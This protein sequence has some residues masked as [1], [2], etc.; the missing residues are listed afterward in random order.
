[1]DAYAEG[2]N[3]YIGDREP[4]ELSLE[5][6]I[7]TGILNR[8]YVIEPWT[9][10][11]SLTWGKA[12]AWDLRGNMGSEIERAILLK[13]F[14][15]E[16]VA[17][18]FPVYPDDHPI[19]VPEIGGSTAFNGEV[20]ELKISPVL[21]TLDLQ[22][23]AD[24]FTILDNLLGP[25]GSGIGSNSWAVSGEHTS[26][27][28]PL[29]AN[30]PHLGIQMPSI[31]FQINLHC[32]Q[33][34]EECPF[35]VGGFSFAGVPGVVIGHNDRI[36]W[37]VTNAGPDVMDLYIEK[38]NPDNPNQYEVNGEWVDFDIREEIINVAGDEPYTLTV[39]STRHGPVLTDTYGPLKDQVDLETNP[40]AQPFR[41]KAGVT[42]PENYVISLAWTALVPSSP[43]EAI[44]GFNTAQNWEE[45]REAAR[46]FHVPAQNLIYADV[47]GNIAYQMPGD[48]P[49]RKNG[50]GRLPVPGWTDE[51]E[52]TGYIPFEELPYTV[53]PPSGYIVT[54]NNQVNPWN[55][56]YL[57]STEWAYGF[58]SARI[59][60]MIEQAPG[61]AD[62]AFFQSI[63]GDAKSLNAEVLVPILL[64]ADLGS[65]LAD[66][67]D[68]FFASWDYQEGPDSQ[69]AALFEWFWWNLVMDTFKDDLPENYWPG[70]GS[71]W[72]EVMRNLVDQPN[73][74]WWDDQDSDDMIETR[75]DIFVR[76]FEETVE[77]IRKEYG[78]DHENWPAWGDLHSAT[79]RNATLGES[80]IGPIEALFNRGPFITGGGEGI[81]N[82]TGWTVGESFEVD[83]LPSMRMIV[84]L[85]DLQNSVTAHTTGQSGHAYH[86]PY[87]ALAPLWANV[88]YYPMLWNQQPILSS[89]EGHLRLLP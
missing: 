29:L 79:F 56:P 7:L 83:W 30:D 49:I 5:Y 73:S 85:G 2:V 87:I 23:I 27:G 76:A 80:G 72:Y 38:V 86:P 67:R 75:E 8:G 51:Y 46:H 19:S 70:G 34:T 60:D 39:R 42:L 44:W 55:Y 9:P 50:D 45:F 41:D 69:A 6:L 57:I 16:Q 81:V 15:P 54:A 77:Q 64:E 10:I 66:I 40:E 28:T 25:A 52:W 21:S 32:V 13:T 24:K 43:F 22:P 35:E 82:A 33:K 71:R 1:V 78:K 89:A 17:E 59:V 53:N 61:K 14:T 58:R 18:L 4:L 68:Q 36:A 74:H 84:D 3:A 88:E 65:E 11:H 47:D 63:Q 62:M 37:G 12:M 31:W 48:I 20:S 26:T